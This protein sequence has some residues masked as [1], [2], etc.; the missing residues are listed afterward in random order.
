MGTELVNRGTGEI[1]EVQITNEQ[2]ELI[3]KTVAKD[4]TPEE[5][6]LYFYDCRRRGVHPL[7]KLIHF[8]KRSGKYTP[9]TSIDFMRGR[10]AETGEYAGSDDAVFT[11]E[12]MSQGWAARVTVYRFVQGQ[13]CSFQATARWSEYFPGEGQGFMWKKMPHTMLSKCA[14]ALALRKGFPQQLAGLYA[15]EEM[16]QA[17]KVERTAIKPPQAKTTISEA[18]EEP[19]PTEPFHPQAQSKP[20]NPKAPKDPGKPISEAQKKLIHAKLNKS[21][22]TDEEFRDHFNLLHIA[23]LTMGD[24]NAALQYIEENTTREPGDESAA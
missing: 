3:K 9:V 20:D 7:D 10:A 12:P 21:K 23:D 18:K 15:S 5:L 17:E 14:E 8:T 13:K 11:G 22:L 16:D 24:M 1:T 19:K 2:I 6:Q 4:A